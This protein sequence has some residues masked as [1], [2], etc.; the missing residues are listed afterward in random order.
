[1]ILFLIYFLIIY[2][3]IRFCSIAII[4]TEAGDVE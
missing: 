2:L 4:I 1:M 3:A